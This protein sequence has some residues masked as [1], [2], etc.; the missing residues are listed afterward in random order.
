MSGL[1]P[2]TDFGRH[3]QVSILAERYERPSWCG[4]GDRGMLRKC[5]DDDGRTEHKERYA[6]LPML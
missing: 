1:P 4:R 5:R 6:R 3:I 2:I